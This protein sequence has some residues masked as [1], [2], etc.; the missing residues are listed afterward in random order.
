MVADDGWYID[1]NELVVTVDEAHT[2]PRC[3]EIHVEKSRLMSATLKTSL[4]CIAAYCGQNSDAIAF[5][6]SSSLKCMH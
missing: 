5:A 4:L 3:D 1:I 2:A 6:F